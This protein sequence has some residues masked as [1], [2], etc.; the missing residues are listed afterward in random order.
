MKETPLLRDCISRT[1]VPVSVQNWRDNVPDVGMKNNVLVN[2]TLSTAEIAIVSTLLSPKDV[3]RCGCVDAEG[4]TL[5]KPDRSVKTI[6]RPSEVQVGYLV[7]RF[8]K[9]QPFYLS[10]RFKPCRCCP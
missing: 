7:L 10:R 8:S 5:H 4:E 9:A 2:E 6:S 3:I 1:A